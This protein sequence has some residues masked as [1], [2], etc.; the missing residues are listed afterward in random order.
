MNVKE[1]II[2]KRSETR[3]RVLM[4]GT[5]VS[6]SGSHPVLVRDVS[7]DGA[8]VYADKSITQGQDVCLTRGPIFVAAYVA[9]NRNGV[10]GLKFYHPLSASEVAAGLTAAKL[11]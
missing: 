10:A 5:L 7:A 1:K 3:T 11:V 8:Q 6:A 2:R 9:W 4:S